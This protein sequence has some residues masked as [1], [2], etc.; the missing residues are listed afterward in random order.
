MHVTLLQAHPYTAA[1][2][3]RVAQALHRYLPVPSDIRYVS[4]SPPAILQRPLPATAVHALYVLHTRRYLQR[5]AEC[6]PPCDVLHIVDHSESFLLPPTRARLKIVSCHDLL[7]IVEKSIYRHAL[8]RWLGRWLY[9]ITVRDITCADG[10]V[11]CS[12]ATAQ[13]VLRSFHVAPERLKVAYHGV[14]TDFFV[15]LPEEARRRLR[16]RMGLDTREIAILHVGSNAPYKNLP[17]ALHTVAYLHHSGHPVRWIKAGQPLSPSLH[18][19]AQSLEIA[20]RIHAA[21]NIDDYRLRELYQVCDV[22][23]FPSTR[24]GFGLPVLEALACGTPAVIADTPALNEWAGEVCPSAPP[25]DIPALAEK[26]LCSAEQS[27]F[28]D[29]R[30]RLREFALRYS[31]R[32]VTR[33][34]VQAYREWGAL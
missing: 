26:V 15:P 3:R 12:H 34:L 22:L 1:S 2:M 30:A 11:A 20:E 23:L 28:P 33:Q 32:E 16:Q 25:N 17:A 10:I 13:D 8:S 31:W 19:M 6:I 27:R 4:L 24:E 9:Q 14:D 29:Y 21:S 18:R 5:V 7:P